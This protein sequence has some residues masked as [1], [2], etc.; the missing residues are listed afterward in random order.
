MSAKVAKAWLVSV[1]NLL[2]GEAGAGFWRRWVKSLAVLSTKSA[3]EVAGM[4]TR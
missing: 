2:K 1:P 3:V 4:L